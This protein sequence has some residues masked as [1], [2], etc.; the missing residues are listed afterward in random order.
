MIP[1][2]AF[3]SPLGVAGQTIFFHRFAELFGGHY[4]LNKLLGVFF[5]K[6]NP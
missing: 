5:E 4:L 3:S 6:K 2:W 1:V